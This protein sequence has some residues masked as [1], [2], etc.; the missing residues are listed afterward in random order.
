ME[1][2]DKKMISLEI[3]KDLYQALRREAFEQELTVSA[4]IRNIVEE[5]LNVSKET[6]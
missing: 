5:K 2:T 3:S 4:L 1:K 6:K